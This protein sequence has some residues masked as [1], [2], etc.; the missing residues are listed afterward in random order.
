MN[1]IVLKVLCDDDHVGD[2]PWIL[3]SR[4]LFLKQVAKKIL[5]DLNLSSYPTA[6]A[7]SIHGDGELGLEVRRF[8]LAKILEGAGLLDSEGDRLQYVDVAVQS[9]LNELRYPLMDSLLGRGIKKLLSRGDRDVEVN[10]EILGDKCTINIPASVPAVESRVNERG[11]YIIDSV[12]KTKSRCALICC[13]SWAEISATFD[14]RG[15]LRGELDRARTGSRYVELAGVSIYFE[16]KRKS[17]S[18]AIKSCLNSF[19]EKEY[20]EL[21]LKG[22]LEDYFSVEELHSKPLPLRF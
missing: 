1:R 9:S 22:N 10:L 18:F 21:K 20:L 6:A 2:A 16:G 19:D 12:S 15:E 13:K 5:K 17:N 4:Y 11:L 14:P 8:E 3:K 7:F